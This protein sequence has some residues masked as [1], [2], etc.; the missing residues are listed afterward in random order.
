MRYLVT[1]ITGSLGKEVSTHLLR[2]PKNEVVGYS[3]DECKQTFIPQHERLT[4]YLGDVR[5]SKRL[6]EAARGVDLIFHFAALKHVDK[7]ETNP[8]EAIMTNVMGTMNVLHAQREWNIPRVVL[9]ST[10]KAA[11]PV[12]VYGASKL[13]SERLVTRNQNN[14]VC[15]YGNVLASR[16]SVI[17]KF[18]T[19]LKEDKS[20]GITDVN[21]TRFWI[22]IEEAANFVIKQSQSKSGGLKI[23]EMRAATLLDIAQATADC[24][25][26]QSYDIKHIGGRP[27][28]K[29]SEC[30]RTEYEG[31]EIFS[32]RVPMYSGSELMEML[33]PIVE[34]M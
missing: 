3:R 16:G 30:L 22:T 4:L 27:G 8:E 24:L 11:Y 29:V 28:E 34:R 23:P 31:E 20:V 33:K 14:V 32:H 10:D 17:E 21:M 5:D 12:N 15:R 18:V 13:I 6:S 2:D 19:S 25:K 9:S 26:M 1:G 7:L